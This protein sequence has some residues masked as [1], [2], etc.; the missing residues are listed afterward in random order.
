MR[1][2][3]EGKR[4]SGAAAG[5]LIRE[6]PA[7]CECNPDHTGSIRAL[8]FAQLCRLLWSTALYTL[9][10][11]ETL[12]EEQLL[13]RNLPFQTCTGRALQCEEASEW[14]HLQAQLVEAV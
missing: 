14:E 6:R 3:A 2:E 8:C 11:S 1:R 12:V 13:L 10:G 5:P 4:I 7:V 9:R